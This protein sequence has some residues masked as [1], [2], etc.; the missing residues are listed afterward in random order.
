MVKNTPSN[1][2]NLDQIVVSDRNENVTKII[3]EILADTLEMDPDKINIDSP[4]VDYGIDSI[5][6]VEGINKINKELKINLRTTDFFNY[7]SIRDLGEYVSSELVDSTHID[8]KR[9]YPP[10]NEE[11]NGS[12]ALNDKLWE[13][14]HELEKGTKSIDEVDQFINSI[15]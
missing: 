14:L 1:E 11:S 13:M 2:S 15:A 4:Y 9:D 7:V 6:A 12:D 8:V 5:L 10:T 3:K